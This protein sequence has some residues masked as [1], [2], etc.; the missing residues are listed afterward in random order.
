VGLYKLK[1]PVDPYS[2]KG[3]RRPNPRTYEAEKP[4]SNFAF[5]M[6]QLVPLRP[7]YIFP[8]AEFEQKFVKSSVGGA[9][10]LTQ[11]NPVDP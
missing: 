3:A 11:L 8:S 10:Q 2:L 6:G 9:V 4:V 5:Q 1:K 7:G